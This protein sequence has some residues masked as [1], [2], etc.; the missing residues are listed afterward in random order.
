M[1]FRLSDEV[2]SIRRHPGGYGSSF[3][4]QHGCIWSI[5]YRAQEKIQPYAEQ[6]SPRGPLHGDVSFAPAGEESDKG[7]STQNSFPSGSAITTQVTSSG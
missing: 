6:P 5:G 2:R 1:T 7:A 4:A 3:A